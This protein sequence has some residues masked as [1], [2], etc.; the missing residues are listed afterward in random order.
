MKK[1]FAAL[2]IIGVMCFSGCVSEK[3][4]SGSSSKTNTTFSAFNDET[5]VW[6]SFIFTTNRVNEVK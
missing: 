5:Y 1:L 3:N 4:C 6:E 2:T